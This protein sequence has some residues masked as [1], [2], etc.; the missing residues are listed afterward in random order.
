MCPIRQSLGPWV[1]STP[2]ETALPEPAQGVAGETRA[3]NIRRVVR[4]HRRGLQARRG[5]D[6]CPSTTKTAYHDRGVTGVGA[7]RREPAGEEVLHLL[8]RQGVRSIS[9]MQSTSSHWLPGNEAVAMCVGRCIPTDHERKRNKGVL[10][11]G[12]T[13]RPH[14]TISCHE[15]AVSEPRT[16]RG[17]VLSLTRVFATPGT[18]IRFAYLS[19][20]LSSPPEVASLYRTNVEPRTA[21]TN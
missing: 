21:M 6:V 5:E 10:Y 18:C 9:D 3:L 14:H 11:A 15:P 13:Q 7:L 19:S 2:R 4:V 12:F 17:R 8:R 16:D 20:F 1:T